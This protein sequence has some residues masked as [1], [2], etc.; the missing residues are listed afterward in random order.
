MKGDG[1]IIGII[2]NEQT[3]LR[4]MVVGPEVSRIL[5]DY[6]SEY[7]KV[8]VNTDKHHEQ[9]GS[10]HTK[11]LKDG[12]NLKNTIEEAGNPCLEVNC[13]LIVTLNTRVIKIMINGDLIVTLNTRVIKIM[14]CAQIKKQNSSL[15]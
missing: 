9:I 4:W 8:S 2:E 1:G 3:L 13:D 6:S 5:S 7:S 12:K 14:K 15:V 10:I 11:F